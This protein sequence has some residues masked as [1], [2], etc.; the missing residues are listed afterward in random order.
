MNRTAHTN[1]ASFKCMAG[2]VLCVLPLFLLP[3]LA[4]AAE[5]HVPATVE[6]GQSFSIPVDG[7]GE[8]TFY[9]VGPDHVVKRTVRLARGVQIQSSEV[10]AAGRYQIIL[11]DSSSPCT[12]ATFEVKAA[13]PAHL[14]FF[15]HP[16]R[17]PV[18]TPGSIDATAF[19]FDQYFNLVLTPS[20]VDFRITPATG[21]GF[22]RRAST[23]NGVA[24]MR[25]DST[26]HE[27][28]VQVTAALGSVEEARV[29][30]QVAAEACGLRMKAVPSGNSVTLE[31]DPVRD[32]S[33]N[34]L[35]DGTVVSFTK[36]D[37]A[38]KS[39][40]DTPIKK[41]IARAQFSVQGR[42]QVSVA[43]GVVLGNEVALNG[44]L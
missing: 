35:P 39:T 6:A 23:R 13:A 21:A 34:A 1:F 5:M 18:S 8:A 9:L 32:C 10:R 37:E 33:G 19:V 27:G 4:C 20:A 17:V 44:K 38:G 40:V 29:I 36:V 41:G 11:C 12:S 42:A 7:S 25:M 22:V 3:V 16:S 24:W 26:P 30:Q 2:W 31:T 28:R 14:S 15:L 43:C